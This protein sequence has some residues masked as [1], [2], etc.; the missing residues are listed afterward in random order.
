[1]KQNPNLNPVS[2]PV[3]STV[4]QPEVQFTGEKTLRA[5]L[6]DGE[7]SA[8]IMTDPTGLVITWNKA[9]ET[10]FGYTENEI[11]GKSIAYFYL[12][13]SIES[14]EHS[15]N[16]LHAAQSPDYFAEGWRVKKD[17][18]KFWA[19]VEYTALFDFERRLLGFA[20]TVRELTENKYITD[21]RCRI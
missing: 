9:A 10:I 5:I 6:S 15:D 1:M 3:V 20:I 12:A 21:G 13:C 11:I 8:M 17:G 7:D 19:Y 4:D 2:S 16:L 14:G 18:T